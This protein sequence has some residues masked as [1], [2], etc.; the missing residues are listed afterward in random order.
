MNLYQNHSDTE[1]IAL[2]TEGD[3]GAFEVIYRKYAS[4]LYRYARKNISVKEDCEEIIQDV[5]ESLWTRHDELSHVTVLSA[6]LFRMV[7]YKVIRYFQHSAVKKRYAEH[8]LL[9][10]AI[11]ESSSLEEKDGS[12]VLSLIDKGLADLPERCRMAVKLRLTEDLSN[13]DIAKRMNIQKST[14]ENYMVTAFNHLRTLYPNLYKA[15]YPEN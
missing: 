1:L 4:D 6:Y 15:T 5:F 2:L 11:Y 12:R 13:G 9:F 3:R 8:Y 7:K 14:V 10:E